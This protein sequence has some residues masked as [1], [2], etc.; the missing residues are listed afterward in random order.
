LTLVPVMRHRLLHVDLDTDAMLGVVHDATGPATA[1]VGVDGTPWW[2]L[3]R[4][5]A[6]LGV[7]EGRFNQPEARVGAVFD[8]PTLLQQG[9]PAN[10]P[11]AER[12]HLWKLGLR[13]WDGAAVPHGGWAS[14]APSARRVAVRGALASPPAPGP[15]A[16][17]A[18]HPKCTRAQWSAPRWPIR[19]IAPNTTCIG[20]DT[21]ARNSIV[22]VVP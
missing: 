14:P 11:V 20:I 3:E 4:G 2:P 19:P 17:P 15:G 7:D 9:K 12:H 6:G 13:D 10:I 22:A 1:E 8:M 16:G 5:A 18:A 21:G